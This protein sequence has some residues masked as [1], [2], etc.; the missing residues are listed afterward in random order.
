M[1]E[2]NVEI[3]LRPSGSEAE[4]VRRCLRVLLGTRAGTLALDR[5]F[6]LDWSFLDLP[7]ETAKAA[8]AAEIYA[9]IAKYEPRA[10]LAQV[11]F[12]SDASGRFLPRI[13]VDALNV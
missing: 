1:A 5:D 8:C 4:D 13:E 11:T 12:R 9:K 6:G 2:N 7:T 3:T 10:H